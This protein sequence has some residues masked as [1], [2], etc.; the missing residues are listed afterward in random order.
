MH[1]DV[2]LTLGRNLVEAAATGITLHIDDTQ[3]VAGILAD[4]LERGEQAR[5]NLGL[6]F[7]SFLLQLILLSAGLLDNLIELALLQVQ[8]TLLLIQHSLGSLQ[9]FLLLSDAALGLADF[10]VTEL[11]LQRLILNLLRQCVVLTV[12]AHVVQLLL[13]AGH[14]VLGLNNLALLLRDGTFEL[15]N[16]ALDALHASVHTFN[17]SL[18]VLYLQ[19]QFT[20][21]SL[22]L[23]DGRQGRLQLEEGLQFL[24]Y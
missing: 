18:E 16:L 23:V 21:Q 22:F 10:L 7:L 20:T 4:A 19:G 11:N 24:F 14:D 2:Q 3:T 15:V 12:V 9:F 6:I 13:V 5:L 8:V 1:L 17:L